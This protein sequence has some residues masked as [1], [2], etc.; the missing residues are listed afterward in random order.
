MRSSSGTRP[1]QRASWAGQPG[2]G[3]GV[4]TNRPRKSEELRS[5]LEDGRNG[6]SGSGTCYLATVHL[7]PPRCSVTLDRPSWASLFSE[8]MECAGVICQNHS[9]GKE[10]DGRPVPLWLP[11]VAGCPVGTPPCPQPGAQPFVTQPLVITNDTNFGELT[12]I[13]SCLKNAFS[14]PLENVKT[15]VSILQTDQ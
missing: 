15:H 7:L 2:G 9:G 11:T 13:L 5:R 4:S 12:A 1:A 8:V 14:L 6:L 3:G 10:R